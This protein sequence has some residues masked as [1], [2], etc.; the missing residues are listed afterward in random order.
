MNTVHVRVAGD[1]RS[2]VGGGRQQQPIELR[3]QHL[4]AGGDGLGTVACNRGELLDVSFTLPPP[5]GVSRRPVEVGAIDRVEDA[6][7]R[8]QL[9]R[10]RRQRLRR[11]ARRVGGPGQHA[12]RVAPLREQVSDGRSGRTSA[13]YDDI[14]VR[15]HGSGDY[16]AL[17]ADCRGTFSC[18][19]QSTL[20]AMPA[21]SIVAA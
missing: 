21:S 10:A 8:E 20:A 12:H 5:D 3:T 7:L 9:A 14:D 18:S 13:D 1:V 2:G 6:D 15:S 11:A 16:W 19:R 17:L 4:V